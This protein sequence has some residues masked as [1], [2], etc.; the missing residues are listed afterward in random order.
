MSGCSRWRGRQRGLHIVARQGVDSWASKLWRSLFQEWE[1][2]G[3]GVGVLIH[4][5]RHR[6]LMPVASGSQEEEEA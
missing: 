4:R 6:V 2:G 5:S 1:G 3:E